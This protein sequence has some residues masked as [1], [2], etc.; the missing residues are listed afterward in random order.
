LFGQ[1][2]KQYWLIST[3][4]GLQEVQ[5]LLVGPKQVKHY[6]LHPTHSFVKL[7]P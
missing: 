3:E 1:V 5:S 6:I 7:D 4:P 2:E